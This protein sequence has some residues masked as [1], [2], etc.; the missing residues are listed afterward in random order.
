M[1]W[2]TS[3]SAWRRHRLPCGSEVL[4]LHPR[5]LKVGDRYYDEELMVLDLRPA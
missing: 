5:V 3:G 1:L 4:G 2:I